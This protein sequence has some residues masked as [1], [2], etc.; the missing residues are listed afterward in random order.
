MNIDQRLDRVESIEQ[1]RSLKALYCELCDEGYDADGLC[2]LFT[3]DAVWDGGRLG[4]F[5]G[6]ERLHRFFSNMP[7]VMSFAIH[8]VT[9]SAVELSD[10]GQTA[11]ARWYLLQMA[12]LNSENKAVWLTGRYI[13]QLVLQQGS[14]KFQ[15]TSLVARF[16]SPYDQGWAEVPFLEVAV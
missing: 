2:N 15:H 12:T 11:E 3:D 8:H 10:D 5:E 7:N 16:F 6:R 1:I 4:R 9:N 14:W 13:D